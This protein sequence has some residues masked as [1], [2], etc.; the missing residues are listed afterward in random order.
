[1]CTLRLISDYKIA[2]TSASSNAIES[3]LKNKTSKACSSTSAGE[4]ASES[5]SSTEVFLFMYSCDMC[6]GSHV[7]VSRVMCHESHFV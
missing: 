4:R 5:G 3:A 6:H 1:M 7:H 2:S